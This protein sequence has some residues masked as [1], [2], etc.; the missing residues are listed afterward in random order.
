MAE[1]ASLPGRVAGG[2]ALAPTAAGSLQAA[3]SRATFAVA[4]RNLGRNRKRTALTASAVGF[5]SMLLV[6]AMSMQGG[7][8]GAMV[9]N[10]TR[11]VTGHL[12]IQD[13]RFA[14]DPKMRYYVAGAEARVTALEADPRVSAASPRIQAFAVL[15]G[16]DRSFG[17]QIMG[18]DPIRER[19][20]SLLPEFVEEGRWLGGERGEL[21]LGTALA[22]NLDVALGDEVVVLG[23]APDGSIAAAVATL[24]GLLGTG[25]PEI[26]RSLAQMHIDDVREAFLLDDAAHAIVV[27]VADVREADA[28][29]APLLDLA[30][31]GASDDGTLRARSWRELIPELEQMIELDKASAYFFYVLLALMVTFSITNTFMMTVF[32]RTREFGTLLAIGCR[33]DFV[34]ALLQI[35]SLL[36]CGLG[37]LGGTV[38]GLAVTGGLM[39]VGIPLDEMGTELLRQYHMPERLYPTPSLEAVLSGPLF[40]LAATQI[41][42]LLPALRLRGLEPVAALR[43]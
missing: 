19:G 4:W 15:S 27:T 9:D 2:A 36:L 7:S 31:D 17:A 21:V 38:L 6:F 43:D 5:A 22:R 3:A 30:A 41:A 42:A 11:L 25:Q 12:Q 40:M 37:V 35:E 29:A 23:T 33:P 24:V 34:I 32:E 16:A 39:V 8:Y 20:F 14:D 10:A 28:L 18:I 26:D 1:S 13:A